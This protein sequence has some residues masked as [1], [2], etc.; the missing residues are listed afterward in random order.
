MPLVRFCRILHVIV[1]FTGLCEISG[2]LYEL[3]NSETKK[4]F[5]ELLK[6]L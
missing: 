2:A 6:L 3:T 4:I 1:N 5:D